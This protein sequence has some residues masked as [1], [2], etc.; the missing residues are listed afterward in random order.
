MQQAEALLL[1]AL[2]EA[3]RRFRMPPLPADVRDAASRGAET[4][5]AWAIEAARAQLLHGSQ[6]PA[7]VRALFHDGLTA[8]IRASLAP[9]DGDPAFQAMVLQVQDARVNEYVRLAGQL[10]ADRRAVRTAVDAIAHPGKLRDVA[11]DAVRGALSRLHALAASGAWNALD[12]AMQDLLAHDGARNERLRATAQAIL[13]HPGLARLRRADALLEHDAVRRY[14]ALSEQQGPVAGSAAAAAQGR[15]AAR[16]GEDAERATARALHAIAQWLQHRAG[17]ACI[18]RVV[19]SLRTPAGFPGEAAKAKDEWDAA[20]LRAGD[21][22]AAADIVLLAEVKASPA[23]VTSDA[24]RLL[25]GLLRLAHASAGESYGFASA[26]GRMLL[27]GASLRALRPHGRALPANVIYCCTA[28]AETHAPMLSAASKAALLAEPASLAFAHQL[29][30]GASPRADEL[31]PVWEA[32]TTAPRLRSTL[33]QYET[34][35]GMREAMLHP[36]DLAR[37][38]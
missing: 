22:N 1:A 12:A 5:L 6:A 9:E 10:T 35:Q 2:R 24:S 30:R 8:L 34:A 29:A 38:L 25:R 19:R 33:H 7:Q 16:L 37:M 14:L 26:D 15:A 21:A 23:A 27:A 20:I 32:L 11:A 3:P 36:D 28:P 17:N 13:A 4:A 31:A 18:Y